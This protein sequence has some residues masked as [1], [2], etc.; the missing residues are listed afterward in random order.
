MR[1]VEPM[2]GSRYWPD[3]QSA[4]EKPL[5][6]MFYDPVIDPLQ[7]RLAALDEASRLM[8]NPDATPSP[9]PTTSSS[10]TP[11]G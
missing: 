1:H 3:V 2:P 7:D 8:F 6:S 9:S 4:A 10:G 11:S 5:T